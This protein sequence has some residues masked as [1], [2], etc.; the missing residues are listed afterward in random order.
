MQ[1]FDFTG[2]LHCVPL[3]GG[4]G[5]GRSVPRVVRSTLRQRGPRHESRRASQVNRLIRRIVTTS[6]TIASSE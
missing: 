4:L 2:Q 6:M 1:R 5:D 3:Q